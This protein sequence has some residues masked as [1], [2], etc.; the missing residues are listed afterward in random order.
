MNENQNPGEKQRPDPSPELYLEILLMR[1]AENRAGIVRLLVWCVFGLAAFGYLLKSLNESDPGLTLKGALWMAL[2][3]ACGMICFYLSEHS[4]GPFS[5]AKD[6][7]DEAQWRGRV[8]IEKYGWRRQRP[9]AIQFEMEKLES[10][11]RDGDVLIGCASLIVLA[12]VFYGIWTSIKVCLI[13]AGIT[14]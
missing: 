4:F 8:L 10:A 3:V 5:W 9:D 12:L 2:A 13:R 7:E 14:S 1:R 6:L 11:R